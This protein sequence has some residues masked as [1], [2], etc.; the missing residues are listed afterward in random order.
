VATAD[1]AEDMKPLITSVD[2]GLT[3]TALDLV[4]VTTGAAVSTTLRSTLDCAVRVE[5]YTVTVTVEDV[6]AAKRDTAEMVTVSVDME[7]KARVQVWFSTGRS[8]MQPHVKLRP[9]AAPVTAYWSWSLL[10]DASRAR[11]S[12]KRT[13]CVEPPD[14]TAMILEASTYT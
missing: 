14:I 7:L 10:A 9:A 6:F 12:P 4:I 5:S 13:D 8:C 11:L 3:F 1:D 2:D